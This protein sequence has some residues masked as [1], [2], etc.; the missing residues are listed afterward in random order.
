MGVIY[1]DH[2]V[3]AARSYLSSHGGD[4]PVIISSGAKVDWG[5]RGVP[6]SF[7]VDPDGIVLFHIVGGVHDSDLEALLRQAKQGRNP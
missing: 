2:D 3:D 1:D 4:W 5:V 6:E 7:L